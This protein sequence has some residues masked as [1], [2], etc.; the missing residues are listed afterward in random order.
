MIHQL[1]ILSSAL[2]LA[3]A[4]PSIATVARA[5]RI[6][7]VA[8]VRSDHLETRRRATLDWFGPLLFIRQCQDLAGRQNDY[9]GQRCPVPRGRGIW[10]VL[11]GQ[12]VGPQ[13]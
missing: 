5:A 6:I 3:S 9:K 4:D 8:E 13:P 10:R 12:C 7:L 11:S 1:S 2:V